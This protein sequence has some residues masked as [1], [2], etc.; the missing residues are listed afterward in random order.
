MQIGTRREL[1]KVGH[2]TAEPSRDGSI[3]GSFHGLFDEC[4]EAVLLTDPTG[5]VF[6]ANPAACDLLRRTEPAICAAGR[7]GIV[8]TSDPRFA[9]MN[10]QRVR[11]GQFMGEITLLR[12]DGAAFSAQIVTSAAFCADG[13]VPLTTMIVRDLTEQ[14]AAREELEAYRQ[15]FEDLVRERAEEMREANALV[16]QE[17]NERRRV[18]AEAQATERRFQVLVERSSDLILV[19]DAARRIIYCSP[20]VERLTGYRQDEITGTVADELIDG[21]DLAQMAATR[22]RGRTEEQVGPGT[23]TLRIHHRDG[24]VRWFEWS[25]SRHFDDEAI[26][27]IVVN[28]HDVTERVLA[29]HAVAASEERYRTLAETS[30]DMIYVVDLDLRVAYVN[31]PAAQR[32][33]RSAE[34]LRGVPLA[35]VLPGETAARIV[36]AVRGVLA[37]GEPV[38]TDALIAYPGGESWVSTRLVALKEAGV[39]TAVLGVSRDITKRRLAEDALAESE[40]RYRSLFE[41]SPVAMWEEDHS[42]VKVYLDRLVALGIDDV[43]AYLVEHP[44]EREHCVK[45]ART[46]DV[47]RAAVALFEASGRDDL[48]ERADELYP[49]GAATGLPI[50][51]AAMLAGERSASYEEA[52][53]TLTGRELH[54]LETC[55]VAPNHE[56][57]FDRVY[58]A[59]VDVTERREATELLSRYRLLFA[60]ARDIM[61]FVRAEDGRIMEANSAAEAA[62]GYSR[63]E[64]LRLDIHG[65]RIDD[66]RASAEQMKAAAA[67]GVLFETEHRRKDGSRFPVEVSS[68]GIIAFDGSTLLL[69]VI[70]DITDRKLTEHELAQAGERLE[71]T[72]Q[73][74]VAALGATV[75][76]RDPYTAGHQ[77]RVAELA[78]AIAAEL[79]WEKGRIETLRTAALLHDIGKIVVPAEILSKPGR[80]SEN[81]MQLIRQHAHAGADLIAEIEFG[82]AVATIVGQHHERLD[83]TGYPDGLDDAE[84]LPEARVLAVADVVE[85]MISH[86]PYRPALSIDAAVAELREGAGRRYDA[87]ACEMAIRLIREKGFSFA[88]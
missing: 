19:V 77:R 6:A 24:S 47:N 83:G 4:P 20:S 10:E 50:L 62:Y 71:R 56:R 7:L 13:A 26:R 15:R 53:V 33:G 35:K 34:T 21:E 51:W 41:D 84:I 81:E 40:R 68:R 74:A 30:P 52:N 85:A 72:V 11:M 60:E 65:L 3:G 44:A 17:L 38:E 43:A 57:A 36:A 63:A 58:I 61:L 5:H 88:E 39:V 86:R 31:G 82:S 76:L 42:A 67:G 66:R 37:G 29:E 48:L 45:L 9:A 73:T 12:G 87:A 27:G 18:E 46:L 55:I 59:D 22:R 75:E 28:A 1:P 32:L 69:S 2:A 14:N 54:V 23:G 64:L 8:D 25:A 70:R 80:L 78:C 49:S 16:M 79:D